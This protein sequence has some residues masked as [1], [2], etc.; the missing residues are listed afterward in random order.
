MCAPEV[1]WIVEQHG[2]F[3][4]YYYAHHCGGD[5]N[6]RERFRD[7]PLVSGVQGFLRQLGSVLVRPGLSVGA[8]RAPSSRVVREIFSRPAHDP[9]YVGGVRAG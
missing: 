5:R 7:H 3:Q 9:R 1:T 4:S 8:A 6:A 2:L